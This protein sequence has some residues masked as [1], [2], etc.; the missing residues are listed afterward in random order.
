VTW[1][2]SLFTFWSRSDWCAMWKR[3]NF[4]TFQVLLRQNLGN[5]LSE[6]MKSSRI[7]T[8]SKEQNFGKPHPRVHFV[9]IFRALFSWVKRAS[10]SSDELVRGL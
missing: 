9:S 6:F 1:N 3:V 2:K 4:C 8:L 10:D 5:Y 7:N